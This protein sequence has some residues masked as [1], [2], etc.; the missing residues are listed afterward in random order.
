MSYYYVFSH[1]RRNG[2]LAM[3]LPSTG[4]CTVVRLQTCSLGMG[5]QVAICLNLTDTYQENYVGLEV[6]T[7]VTMKNAV[8]CD[9]TL[10]LRSVCRLRLAANVVPSSSILVTLMMEALNP[11]ETSVLTRATRRNIPEEAILHLPGD[12]ALHRAASG[13]AS[14]VCSC[15][16]GDERFGHML[17]T[18]LLRGACWAH[19]GR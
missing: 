13:R 7:V 8:S 4:A 5:M 18:I 1:C 14:V 2:I 3:V 10:F 19:A 11:Y 6:F 12:Y 16:H 17:T 9:V 15:E